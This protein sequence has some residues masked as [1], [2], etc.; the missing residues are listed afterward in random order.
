M[1]DID[2]FREKLQAIITKFEKDSSAGSSLQL[3]PNILYFIEPTTQFQ[4]HYSD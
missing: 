2:S 4:Y 1:S 3:E